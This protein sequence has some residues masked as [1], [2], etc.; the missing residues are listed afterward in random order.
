MNTVII[1]HVDQSTTE[2]FKL[3]TEKLGLEMTI[4]VEESVSE[5]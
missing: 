3:L 1:E 5:D 4:Q 2:L